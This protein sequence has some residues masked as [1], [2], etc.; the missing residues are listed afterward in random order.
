MRLQAYFLVLYKTFIILGAKE[1]FLMQNL[2]NIL[3]F[4]GRYAG[5]NINRKAYGIYGALW[6]SSNNGLCVYVC[7]F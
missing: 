4:S 7:I 2:K 1:I 3:N 5:D 6:K